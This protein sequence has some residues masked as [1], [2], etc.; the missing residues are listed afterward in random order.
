MT[1]KRVYFDNN[2]ATPPDP[3]VIAAV[4]NYLETF[5]GNPSSIHAFGRDC[6]LVLTASRD[7]IAQFLGVRSNEIIFT[8]GGTEGANMVI[9]G[10]CHEPAFHHI[11]TSNLEHASVFESVKALEQQGASV[12]YLSPGSWGGIRAADVEAA[13][14]P[15]TTCIALMAVNGETGVKSEIEAIAAIAEERQIPFF[16]DGVAWIG[17]E[18]FTIPKG[19]SALFFSGQKFHSIQGTG[20]VFV[21]RSLKLRPLISGAAH[22]YGRRGGTEDLPGIV[23]IA[24]AV[25]RVVE[26]LPKAEVRMRAL[27]ERFE[28]LL[29]EAIPGVSVN[30]EGPRVCNCSNL[31][32]PGVDGEGLLLA[33]D[34]AGIAAS[35]GSACSSGAIEPSRVLV[36]MGYSLERV[37]SSLR[38]SLSRFTTEEEIEEVVRVIKKIVLK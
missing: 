24:T 27:R 32:F 31:A 35:H 12:T 4:T 38:F 5:S 17:K 18:L 25:K 19:I 21:R 9:K 3:A 16:V 15:E 22:Q 26:T 33:L 2:A 1:D 34:Q 37:G 30:G 11:I 13:I 20:F 10:F 28:T 8:S 29:M 36:N 14:T 7:S 6:R 23:A